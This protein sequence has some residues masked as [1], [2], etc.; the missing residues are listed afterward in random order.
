MAPEQAA[1]LSRRRILV[2]DDNRSARDI[3]CGILASFQIEATAVSAVQSCLEELQHAQ[4]SG[5]PYDTVLM[6]W[7]MP[8]QDGLTAARLIQ[9]DGSISKDLTMV[10]VT[11]YSRD[12]LLELAGDVHIAGILEKPVSPSTVLDAI[13]HNL[14]SARKMAE[15]AKFSERAQDGRAVLAGARV[16]LVEDNEINQELATEILQEA[17]MRVDVAG[18]G[19]QAVQ[20]VREQKYDAVLMD[21][22]MP[23]MDGFEATRRI[24]E[25][26]E[27]A[28]LPIIAMTA[29]AMGGDREK[30]LAAGMN[31]Y[32]VKPI[33]V[34]QL[35]GALTKWIVPA[36]G[37][38]ARP[39]DID[40]LRAATHTV[41]AS[42]GV[43]QKQFLQELTALNGMNVQAAMRRLHSDEARFRRLL[44]SVRLNHSDDPNRIATMYAKGE[45]EGAHLLAHTLKGLLSNIGAES[46]ADMARELEKATSARDENAMQMTL[47]RM[48]APFALLMKTIEKCVADMPP[49]VTLA[50]PS[51]VKGGALSEQL[52]RLD[53]LLADQDA[54]AVALADSLR[55]SAGVRPDVGLHAQ[56]LSRLHDLIQRYAYEAARAELAALLNLVVDESQAIGPGA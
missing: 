5:R 20:R 30:C 26:A 29:N 17:G 19:A 43:A 15:H 40:P 48:D 34:S 18:D 46:L 4:R 27:H 1:N 53:A 39:N 25:R 14:G 28:G 45:R 13:S 49:G 44:R 10:M 52:R 16:L 55:A 36:R 35:L 38:G 21:W 54:G 41:V 42:D 23:V 33:D 31:D 12:D 2:V 32:I 11:A 47:E 37:V 50:D 6:D 3:L 24:R 51:P 9:A 8:D 56:A 22:H 7:Q